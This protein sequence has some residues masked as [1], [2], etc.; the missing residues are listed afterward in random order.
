MMTWFVVD[1]LVY[2]MIAEGMP[3]MVHVFGPVALPCYSYSRY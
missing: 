3:E 1:F 2:H